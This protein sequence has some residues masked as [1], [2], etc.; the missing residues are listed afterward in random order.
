[1]EPYGAARSATSLLT[2]MGKAIKATGDVKNADKERL[3]LR[4]Q[5]CLLNPVIERLQQ[6]MDEADTAK[7]VRSNDDGTKQL[8]SWYRGVDNLGK[9]KETLTHC[10]QTLIDELKTAQGL[11]KMKNQFTHPW[12]REKCV[13]PFT[14]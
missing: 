2:L 3:K 11:E 12:K 9:L 5:L 8:N 1:M 10:V 14:E 6:R 7:Y 4:D 13:P